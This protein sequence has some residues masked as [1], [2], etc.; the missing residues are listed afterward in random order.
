[1]S[2]ENNDVPGELFQYLQWK[3]PV[4]VQEALQTW[5]GLTSERQGQLRTYISTKRSR[6]RQKEALGWV[7]LL[8]LTGDPQPPYGPAGTFMPPF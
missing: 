8:L 4:H 5:E 2:S 3:H 1:M 7:A 6:R